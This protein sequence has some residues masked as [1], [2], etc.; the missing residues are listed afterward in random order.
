MGPIGLSGCT[1]FDTPSGTSPDNNDKDGRD[2]T[3]APRKVSRKSSKSPIELCFTEQDQSA[4]DQLPPK[5]IEECKDNSFGKS[6]L[7]L[8][9]E[10]LPR[11][12]LELDHHG[13]DSG[14]ISIHTTH[15]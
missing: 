1:A 4:A 11:E 13:N 8:N 7:T 15:S 10:G 9:K 12:L 6:Q 3:N 2:G 5:M 14:D